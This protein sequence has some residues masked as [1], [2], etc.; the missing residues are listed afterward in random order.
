MEFVVSGEKKSEVKWI[1]KRKR[2]E[3]EK[4]KEEEEK[5][6]DDRATSPAAAGKAI[7]PLH[8]PHQAVGCQKMR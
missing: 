1:E 5:E 4:E 8:F 6:D 3:E 2:K 7:P